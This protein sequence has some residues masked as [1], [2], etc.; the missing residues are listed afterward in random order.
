MKDISASLKATV[1]YFA[2]K[3]AMCWSEMPSGQYDDTRAA[4][5]AEDL[6]AAIRDE[7]ME[8]GLDKALDN[9]K[10]GPRKKHPHSIPRD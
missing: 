10:S 8:A 5:Y 7:M 3:M 4:Q 1:H 2:G 9:E 6:I